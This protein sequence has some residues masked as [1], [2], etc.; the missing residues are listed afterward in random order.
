MCINHIHLETC[1]YVT[2]AHSNVG[3][4]NVDSMHFNIYYSGLSGILHWLNK[5]NRK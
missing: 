1:K 2:Y 5:L 3:F 4:S